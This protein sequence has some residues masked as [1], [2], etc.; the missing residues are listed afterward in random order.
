MKKLRWNYLFAGIIGVIVIGS[1]I[2]ILN[3]NTNIE[4]KKEENNSTIII[5][6]DTDTPL[7]IPKIST[8]LH[9]AEL[10]NNLNY[11]DFVQNNLA[12][13][14]LNKGDINLWS[15]K[16]RAITPIATQKL[17][18]GNYLIALRGTQ[19]S[20]G[21]SITFV[22]VDENGAVQNSYD[23]IDPGLQGYSRLNGM[24]EKTPTGTYLSYGFKTPRNAPR[25]ELFF[26]IDLTK[27]ANGQLSVT[28][29]P[30][31]QLVKEFG[32]PHEIRFFGKDSHNGDIFI[33]GFVSD[34]KPG[35]L[36]PFKIPVGTFNI[37]SRIATYD[38]SL[39]NN[40]PNEIMDYYKEKG[41]SLTNLSHI[42]PMDIIKLAN[43][44]YFSIIN[45]YDHFVN[46]DTSL[47]STIQIFDASGARK[48]TIL[49]DQIAKGNST[50]YDE[51]YVIKVED[52]FVY[53]FIK[54]GAKS[55]IK[56]YNFD[57]E[58]TKTI[59]TFP[60][61][62]YLKIAVNDDNSVSFYG[63][64]SSLLEDDFK[65]FYD[66]SGNFIV[67][68]VMKGINSEESFKIE[69]LTPN[70]V[71]KNVL[72]N[73]VDRVDRD[74]Y[75]ISGSTTATN[76]GIPTLPS[77][78]SYS[79]YFMGLYG[80]V[81]HKEDF[82]PAIFA[83]GNVTLNI[84][85]PDLSDQKVLDNWLLTGSKNGNISD[86][87]AIKVTDTTD[88]KNPILGETVQERQVWLNKRINKN[89]ENL[90]LP[91]DWSALGVDLV[92][93]GPQSVTYFIGDSQKQLSSASRWVDA[94]TDQ[95]IKDNE[96]YLDAQNFSIP[97]KSVKNDIPSENI[98]K[99]LAQTK[100]WNQVTHEIYE[101]GK[102]KK[103]SE[104]VTVNPEQL[105][106]LQEATEAKP[107]PVDVTIEIVSNSGSTGGPNGSKPG[108][109]DDDDLDPGGSGIGGGNWVGLGNEPTKVTNRV[110]VFV[111]TK[112]TVVDTATGIVIYA[113]DYKLPLQSAKNESM[114]T[115]YEHANIKVY[116]YYDNSH[117]T[118]SPLPTIADSSKTEGLTIKNL[119]VITDAQKPSI[120]NPEISYTWDKGE[121][122]ATPD[123]TLYAELL[124]HTKQVVLNESEDLPIPNKGYLRLMYGKTHEVNVTSTS[125]IEKNNPAYVTRTIDFNHVLSGN[126]IN[127]SLLVP[128]Y[129][130]YKG[131]T[132]S[133]EDTPHHSSNLIAQNFQYSLTND[134]YEIWL[135]LYIEPTKMGIPKPY[136]WDYQKNKFGKITIE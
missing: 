85:V 82:S 11:H 84:D 4:A 106:T 101:D 99:E 118:V 108:E 36:S 105:K 132:A 68:G 2:M 102:N 3:T 77:N 7:S 1:T 56:Q 66:V 93:A 119:S 135:T 64:A 87:Q 43:G 89:F 72:I 5:D 117:E 73:Y 104:K 10:K 23:E 42:I 29:H 114:S 44:D 80:S 61:E 65:G 40:T 120:V 94:I 127:F 31:T 96:I 30:A 116:D 76:F 109:N 122:F 18:N 100:I 14:T 129:Y 12:T 13:R 134:A 126:E 75:F 123:V 59:R 74:K 33:G 58:T 57:T 54:D 35:T 62:T 50:G 111:T 49:P 124:L 69:N 51:G 15:N 21:G 24:L 48:K 19:K 133:H 136:S 17:D 26:E 41:R 79:P 113:D 45:Y 20:R 86:P 128:E 52:S 9:E 38:L 131:Y 110:W 115:V 103:F 71:N 22:E 47:V 70:P 55:Y 78:P 32:T 88:L 27:T 34:T 37:E 8:R 130:S 112:N 28:S 25:A 81:I 92:N 60:K 107:Y 91:I 46:I 90:D 67:F 53:Y 39:D 125:D 98:F 95:T 6:K 121:S 16:D 63:Y 97:L 83:K